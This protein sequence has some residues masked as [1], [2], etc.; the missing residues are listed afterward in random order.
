MLIKMRYF[1]KH[2]H[3]YFMTEIFQVETAVYADLSI[4]SYYSETRCIFCTYMDLNVNKSL[5]Q[6]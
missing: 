5:V 3:I 1:H 6:S 4:P 2:I